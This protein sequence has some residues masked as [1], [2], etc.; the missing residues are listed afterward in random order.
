MTPPERNALLFLSVLLL[1]GVSVRLVRSRA[2]EVHATRAER[3]ALADQR[4]AVDSV[5]KASRSSAVNRR[6]TSGSQSS[7]RSRSSQNGSASARGG[8]SRTTSQSPTPNSQSP[9]ASQPVDL[10][11]ATRADIEALPWIGP[12]LADRIVTNRDSLGPFGS[13][14]QFQ[15]VYG[16][17]PGMARRLE[18]RVTFSQTPRHFR[19]EDRGKR[20]SSGARGRPPARPRAP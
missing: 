4:Q 10:D 7:S 8:R 1:L 6:S 19:V 5:R 3:E 13:M 9:T 12:V 11:V 18:G 14:E 17:G 2:A 16:I 15:R 20:T